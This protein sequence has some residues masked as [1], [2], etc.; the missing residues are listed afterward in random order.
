MSM[1]NLIRVMV[2]IYYDFTGGFRRLTVL[3]TAKSNH[4]CDLALLRC[5]LKVSDREILFIETIKCMLE[6]QNKKSFP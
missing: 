4:K 3:Y 5:C 2:M 6:T 1:E